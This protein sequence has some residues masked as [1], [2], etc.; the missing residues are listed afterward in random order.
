MQTQQ[1]RAFKRATSLRWMRAG[2]SALLLGFALTNLVPLSMAADN[3]PLVVEVYSQASRPLLGKS[4]QATVTL[5]LLDKVP[6]QPSVIAAQ[7]KV[8]IEGDL[9]EGTLPMTFNEANKVKTGKHELR[10][11][12]T[13]QGRIGLQWLLNAKPLNGAAMK[14]FDMQGTSDALSGKVNWNGA[15]RLVTV[16]FSYGSSLLQ[17]VPIRVIKLKP[18]PTP[19]PMVIITKPIRLKPTPTP[20]PMI[21]ITKPIKL[22]PVGRRVKVSGRLVVTNSDD[23]IGGI[24]GSKDM[25]V[26][27]YGSIKF[28]EQTAFS[29]KNRSATEGSEIKAKA[30]NIVEIRY[31]DPNRFFFPVSG[32]IYDADKASSSDTLWSGSHRI[33]LLKILE[34]NKEYLIKGDRDSESADLYIRVTDEGEF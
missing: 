1:P 24:W 9:L 32:R 29:L 25:Q 12:V 31:D 20:K 30:M 15:T 23:G 5:T 3:V 8:R 14:A 10:F 2:V 26:E 13:R 6:T 17:A 16:T 19:K 4:V 28:G 22:K 11:N 18:T 34:S 7:G 27:L 21:I 33:D